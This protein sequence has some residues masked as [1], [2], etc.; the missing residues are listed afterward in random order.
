MPENI[1]IATEEEYSIAASL[2]REYASWLNIDLGFQHFEKELL[3]LKKMYAAPTG[4]I[5]ICKM[6]TDYIGCI[7]IRSI[8]DSVAE[9]KRMYVK[10]AFQKHGIG[11][12]LLEGALS[13]ANTLG[14]KKIRL[15]TLSNMTP[16]I[17]LYK[18]YG[19]YEI[20]AYYYNPEKT[21]VFFEKSLC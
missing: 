8:D 21:A 20:P 16:A 3:E 19:F 15:D 10:P 7:A 4:G 13:L 2:F 5:I 11:S 14:Y 6:G 1:H 17:N 18:K 12:M 9:L